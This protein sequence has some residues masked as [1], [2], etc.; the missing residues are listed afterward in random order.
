MFSKFH[1]YVKFRESYEIHNIHK[2]V[3]LA[4]CIISEM[5]KSNCRK[6][7]KNCNWFKRTTYLLYAF[8]WVTPWRLNLI[9]QSF[10]TLCLFHLHGRPWTW[11]R[12]SVPKR[13]RI[14]FRCR[15]IT[16][17]K[18]YNI[19]YMAK[20]WNQEN[21]ISVFITI[22]CL[23]NDYICTNVLWYHAT[24]IQTTSCVNLFVK[25]H[26]QNI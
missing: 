14:K 19:Q 13:W 18:A 20:V 11:N 4:K 24:G 1:S 16:Q 10:G 3:V 8:F 25:L 12:Q 17:K 6:Y 23:S 5:S 2:Y 7:R 9:C 26:T 22:I 15:G 21:K